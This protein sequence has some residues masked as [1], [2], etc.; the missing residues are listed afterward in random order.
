MQLSTTDNGDVRIV[1]IQGDLDGQTA[2]Q[3]Q[4]Q[5]LEQIEAGHHKILINFKDLNFISSAGLRA[6]LVTAKTLQQ[7][8]GQLRI[9]E[10]SPSVREVFEISGFIMIIAV[11][12]GQAEALEKF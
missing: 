1:H 2:P 7:H 8:D 4:Q 9:C 10:V 11:D 6:L 12:E 5:L 3:A